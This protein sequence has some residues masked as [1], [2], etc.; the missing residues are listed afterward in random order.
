MVE[1]VN[2]S[3]LFRDFPLD[4]F[5]EAAAAVCA[6]YQINDFD[7]RTKIMGG[8]GFLDRD[9]SEETASNIAASLTEQGIGAFAVPNDELRSLAEP[10]VMTGFQ[11]DDYG[12]LP[13][14]QSPDHP[15]STIGWSDILVV[16]AGG[17]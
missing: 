11:M 8:W 17:F 13:R 4:H 3:I 15:A 14:L 9:A 2:C 1:R 6:T 12:L 5:D 7:A 16:A 10:M